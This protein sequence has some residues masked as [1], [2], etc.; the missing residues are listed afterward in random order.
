MGQRTLAFTK[1]MLRDFNFVELEEPD[2]LIVDSSKLGNSSRS[3]RDVQRIQT[4]ASKHI[5]A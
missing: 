2:H 1:Q 5:L 3:I 4:D